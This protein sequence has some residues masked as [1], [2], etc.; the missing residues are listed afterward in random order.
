MNSESNWN[1][2]QSLKA[3]RDDPAASAQE[4]ETAGRLLAERLR[5]AGLT[6]AQMNGDAPRDVPFIVSTENLAQKLW[7]R[8]ACW[9][10]KQNPLK[11]RG[12][13]KAGRGLEEWTLSVTIAQEMDIVDATRH[14]MAILQQ[15]LAKIEER[16]KFVKA[17]ARRVQREN[18]RRFKKR[19]DGISLEREALLV[20]M[21]AR[22]GLDV[23]DSGKSGRRMTDDEF[24][25]A[26]QALNRLPENDWKR[27]LSGDGQRA[28]GNGS[29]EQFKLEN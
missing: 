5:K 1:T 22:Y 6:E 18:E 29:E 16:R 20:A 19:L 25:A 15:E 8:I 21:A 14:Y 3:M 13:R 27:K 26:Q 4:R 24:A 9:L 28:L 2:L 10:L 7:L 12:R 11:L 17:E 23:P